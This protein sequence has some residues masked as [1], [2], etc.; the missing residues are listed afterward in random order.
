[1]TEYY[2]RFCGKAWWEEDDFNDSIETVCHA[3]AEDMT[4]TLEK[5]RLF[6]EGMH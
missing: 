5:H 3:C 2:C 6:E 1:M 4:R